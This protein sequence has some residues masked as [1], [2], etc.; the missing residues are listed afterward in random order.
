MS[1]VTSG[2]V[3]M[4]SIAV[5]E[6][7]LQIDQ[8][9]DVDATAP[10]HDNVIIYKD[11]VVDPTYTTTGWYSEGLLIENLGNV[12]SSTTPSHNEILTYNDTLIDAAYGTGWVNKNIS[13][14]FTGLS[15][16][17]A[18]IVSASEAIEK[19][20]EG[21]LALSDMVM[22]SNSVSGGSGNNLS[23][24]SADDN[25]E[26]F[27]RELVDS[28]FTFVQTL[29]AGEIADLTYT[30]GTIIRSTKGVYGLTGPFPT[31]LGVSGLSF[32]QSR[33][34]TTVASSTVI[35]ASTGTE[36]TVTLFG[37]DGTTI[38]DGPTVVSENA[39]SVFSC[40]ATVGEFVL[41]STGS[42]IAVVNANGTQIRVLP[43]MSSELICWNRAC[44]VSS[45]DGTASVVYTRRN[46]NTG[47]TSVPSG[48]STFLNAGTNVGFAIGGAVILRS[49]KPIS[50]YTG[51]DDFGDQ[52]IPG[53]PLDK[54]S[55]KFCIPS[56]IDDNTDNAIACIAIA[57]PYE[58]SVEIFDN[59]GASVT[60]VNISRP[61]TPATTALEQ[62]F[63]AAA[64][65]QPQD[66]GITMNGGYIICNVPCMCVMNFNGGTVWTGATGDEMMIFGTTPEDIRADIKTDASGLLRRRTLSGAGVVTWEVC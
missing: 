34:A 26:I 39:V 1:V 20:K 56:F 36:V 9:V 12:I 63:P 42:I 54:L 15:T 28:D 18:G 11:S 60:S 29:S 48:T 32:K 57:S 55:Q 27:K 40:G 31:P 33:F 47:T 6:D 23:I 5:T 25:N 41:S 51:D 50:C 62:T 65:W 14:L 49:D 24:G 45:L 30:T 17:I 61:T 59:T 4:G 22:M 16:T 13:S 19:G 35:V 10:V 58:G 66:N 38:I 64:R 44:N 3:S 43:P 46:G 53:L 2:T 21:N 7:S 37:S 52:S 8:L